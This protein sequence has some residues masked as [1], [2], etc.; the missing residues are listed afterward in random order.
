MPPSAYVVTGWQLSG[1][2]PMARSVSSYSRLNKVSNSCSLH[3]LWVDPP[4]PQKNDFSNSPLI[5]RHVFTAARACY[6]P[7]RR[8]G[9]LLW[10]HYPGLSTAIS[11]YDQSAVCEMQTCSRVLISG[12][13]N[14]KG[15]KAVAHLRTQSGQIFS[16]AH[17]VFTNLRLIRH[18]HARV[19]HNLQGITE[20]HNPRANG[21]SFSFVVVPCFQCI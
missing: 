8:N 19:E 18:R 15:H 10:L 17:T 9:S 13:T 7:F 3:S 1:T 21:W 12:M 2:Y 14:D 5:C 6:R 11:Q 16:V 20:N 4:P